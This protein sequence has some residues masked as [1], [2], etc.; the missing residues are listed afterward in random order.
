MVSNV[1]VFPWIEVSKKASYAD[2]VKRPAKVLSGAN[3]MPIGAWQISSSSAQ[4]G[5]KKS[6]FDR[7]IFPRKSVFDRLSWSDGHT[8]DHYNDQTCQDVQEV[9]IPQPIEAPQSKSAPLNLNLGLGC[10]N[11]ESGDSHSRRKN[12]A[13]SV[14]V[15]CRRCL[16]LS[17]SRRACNFPIKCNVCREWGHVAASCPSRREK[18]KQLTD[19]R[20]LDNF[21][22]N[23]GMVFDCSGWFKA[24]ASMTAGPSTPP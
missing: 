10:S 24:K 18:L 22:R 12:E 2:M 1:P 7:L 21:S 13:S 11:F 14:P 16:S 6:V 19:G 5:P 4:A 17:H 15:L 8:E 23:Y 20:V 3:A 9:H